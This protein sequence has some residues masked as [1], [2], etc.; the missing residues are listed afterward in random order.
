MKNACIIAVGLVGIGLMLATPVW[1]QELKKISLDNASDLGLKIE[2][3]AAVK[4]EGKGSVKITTACPVTV[5][6]APVGG[7]DVED[8]ALIFKAKVKTDIQGEAFLEMWVQVGGKQYFSK[9]MNDPVKGQ[10]EWK[11]IQT[12]FFLQKGQRP[13]KAWLNIVIN[14]QGTVWVDEASLS[15]A[16]LVKK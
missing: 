4:V 8:A 13:E 12:L 9:G 15:K 10:S 11:A 1:P 3:D 5:C 6:L 2:T 16:P 7:L 14:G